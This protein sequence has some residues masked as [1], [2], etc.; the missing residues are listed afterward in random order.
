M[1]CYNCGKAIDHALSYTFVVNDRIVIMCDPCREAYLKVQED[2]AM[3]L[4]KE[5]RAKRRL[6]KK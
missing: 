3:A 2:I 5:A 1:K 4:L 6:K